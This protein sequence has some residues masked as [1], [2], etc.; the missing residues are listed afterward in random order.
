[1]KEIQ[2]RIQDKRIKLDLE[3]RVKD[4]FAEKG[5]DPAY[6]ARPLQRILQKELLSPLAV[7]LIDG[8][9]KP[10]ST[11]QVTWRNDQ[12]YFASKQ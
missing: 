3:E 11:V 4:Y 8:S 6:G 2:E 9:I 12:I 10:D 5:Y 7:K 1:M